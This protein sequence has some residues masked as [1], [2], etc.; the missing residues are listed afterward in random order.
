MK[1][2]KVGVPTDAELE[3]LA[4]TV[5]MEWNW[6]GRRLGVHE[7]ELKGIDR[8]GEQPSKKVFHMLIHW[9]Q[10]NGSEA[11]YK[12]LY[13]ALTHDRVARQDLAEKFCLNG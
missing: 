11:T 9:K 8:G 3:A 4:Y 6:L 5:S 13:D 2:L 10:R 7:L 12:V 1:V